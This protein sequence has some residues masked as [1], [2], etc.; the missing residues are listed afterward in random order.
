MNGPRDQNIEINSEE[1]SAS[2]RDILPNCVLEQFSQGGVPI[3]NQRL[4]FGTCLELE[5]RLGL[6]CSSESGQ[7]PEEGI[8]IQP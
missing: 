5:S 4:E 8:S 7:V 3:L 2:L 6:S 1:F